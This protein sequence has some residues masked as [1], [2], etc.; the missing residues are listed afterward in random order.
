MTYNDILSEQKS[1]KFPVLVFIHG[2]SFEWSSGNPYD[3]RILASYGN[4]MV[5]TINFRLGILGKYF[6]L[7]S[8]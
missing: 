1:K 3:G 5:I 4:I 8:L 2:D 6:Y 7:L